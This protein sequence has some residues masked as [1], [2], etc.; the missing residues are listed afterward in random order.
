MQACL[1]DI[2]LSY[3]LNLFRDKLYLIKLFKSLLVLLANSE[4][5]PFTLTRRFNLFE[6]DSNL[7][8]NFG[9]SFVISLNT[10]ITAKIIVAVRA[11]SLNF[12]ERTVPRIMR[13]AQLPSNMKWLSVNIKNPL[14]CGFGCDCFFIY[15]QLPV[16]CSVSRSFFRLSVRLPILRQGHL[17]L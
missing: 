11:E 1:F 3:K 12:T 15:R 5:I 7:S 17:H 8:I 13:T 4:N 10:H 9:K 2:D 14:S 16:F 6:H